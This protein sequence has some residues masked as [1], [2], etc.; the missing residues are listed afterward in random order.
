MDHLDE[1]P[2]ELQRALAALGERADARAAKVNAERVAARVLARLRE[3]PAAPARRPFL[4]PRVL[5]I[6][7]A[8]AIVVTG[9]AVTRALLLRPPA[10]AERCELP[11]CP[12]GLTAA[13]SDSLLRSLDEVRALNGTPRGSSPEV[14]DLSE[15]QLRALLQAMQSSEE[16][17]L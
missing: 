5:R 10:A 15:P 1:V 6:A 16:G 9:G 14:E 8:V 3:E 7:A 12:T 4:Q 11:V 17:S 2:P 13:Q